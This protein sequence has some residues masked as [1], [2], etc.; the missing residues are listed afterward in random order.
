MEHHA[1]E[2]WGVRVYYGPLFYRSPSAC[3]WLCCTFE[4]FERWST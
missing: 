3:V 1:V 4:E 2:Y